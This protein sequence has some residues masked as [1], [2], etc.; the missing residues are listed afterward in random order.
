MHDIIKESGWNGRMLVVD[1]QWDFGSINSRELH[2]RDKKGVFVSLSPAICKIN[3][4]NYSTAG[5][6]QITY[7]AKIS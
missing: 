3:I 7:D 6:K 1:L 5:E 4:M 2:S